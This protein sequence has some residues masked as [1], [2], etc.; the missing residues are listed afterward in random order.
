LNDNGDVAFFAMLDDSSKGIYTGAD[1]VADKVLHVGDA[2]FGATL[3]DLVFDDS[4]N[5][6]GQLAFVY[7]LDNGQ[8]GVA[9][10]TPVPEPAAALLMAASMALVVACRRR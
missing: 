9:V 3:I 4:F 8:S 2:L 1:P 7:V 10:A 6:V 5:D